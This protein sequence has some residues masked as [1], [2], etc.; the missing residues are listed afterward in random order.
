[1]SMDFSI[2][3]KVTSRMTPEMAPGT[4]AASVLATASEE[5]EA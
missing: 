4:S 1:M 2:L 3:A 5:G